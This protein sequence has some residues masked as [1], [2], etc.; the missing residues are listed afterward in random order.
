MGLADVLFNS[1]W[2][3]VSKEVC[4][5]DRLRRVGCW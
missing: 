1:Q 3:I 2:F 4:N 5:N